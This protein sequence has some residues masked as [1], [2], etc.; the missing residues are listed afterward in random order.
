MTIMVMKNFFIFLSNLESK[1]KNSLNV[2]IVKT[3]NIIYFHTY[4]T[5]LYN[6]STFSKVIEYIKT[7]NVFF[8]Y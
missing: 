4:E 5:Y 3:K 8:P 6:L 7:V 2:K 1:K